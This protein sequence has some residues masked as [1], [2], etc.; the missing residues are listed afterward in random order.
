MSERKTLRWGFYAVLL[1]AGVLF[2]SAAFILHSETFRNYALGKIIQSAEQSTGTRIAVKNMTLTWYPLGVE[3]DDVTAQARDTAGKDPLLTAAHVT[4][5]LKLLPLLHR[6]VEVDKVSVDRPALHLRTESSGRTNLPASPKNQQQNS[7]LETQVALLIIRDGLIDYDDRRI[8]LSAELRGFRSQ[9]VFD[10]ATSSY[11]GQIAY[12]L[13]R[14][15]TTGIRTFDHKAEL[16]FVADATHC[17]VEHVDLSTLQSHLSMHGDLTSYT[18]PV[19][20]GDYT[21][22]ISGEDLR[23][24][25]NNASVPAGEVSLQGAVTYRS[26]QGQTVWDRT[27]LDG[28]LESG[29]LRLSENQSKIAV[30]AV[31]GAYRLEHGEL[32]LE[33]VRADA[34]GGHLTS[35]FDVIDLKASAGKIH[36]AIRGASVEQAGYETGASNQQTVHVAGMADLDIGASWKNNIHNVV[37]RA[38]VVIRSPAGLTPSRNAIP[39]EG[40]VDVDYDAARDRTSFGQSHLRTGNTQL[41]V[42][43]ILSHDS[44]LSVQLT[45]RDLQELTALVSTAMPSNG[46]ASV[47][48]YDLHGAAEFTGRLSGATKNPHIDGRISGAGIQ[49][50]GTKWR[51]LRAHV[52]LD[53]HA[54]NLDDGSLVGADKGRISFSGTAKLANW[55]LDPAAPVSLHTRIENVSAAD[56]QQVGK[57]SYPVQG[58]L[59]G[60]LFL[61]GSQRHP[62]GRGH[63]EL[64]QGVAW[65]EPLNAFG[66]DF[67]ADQQ[68]VH[69]TALARSLAGAVTARVTYD[70]ESRHYQAHANTQGLNLEQVHILQQAEGS[71]TGQMTAEVSGSGTLDDPQWT[72]RVQIPSLQVRGEDFKE[73]DA[74]VSV[75]HKHADLSFHSTVEQSSVQIKGTVELT[76]AYPAKVIL[77]TGEVPIGPL[78]DKFMHGRAQGATGQMEIHAT[79][80]G[81]L[82]EPARFEGHAEIPTLHL[83]AKSIELSNTHAVTLDYRA[84]VLQVANAELKGS[85]TDIR[86]NGSIPMQGSG[87]MNLTANGTLDLKALDAWANGGHSSGQ[88][89]LQLHA[90][91]NKTQ[92]TVEGNVRIVNAVYT[93]DALP[94]GIESLNGEISI[95][96]SRLQVSNLSATAGGGTL[97]VGGSATYGQN[98]SF[99][100]AL[101]AKSVRVRQ[102]GVRAV[103]D[104]NLA[105]VGS[106]DNSTLGGRVTIHKL[107]FNQAADLADIVGQFSNDST[108][109]E[110][111]SLARHLKLSVAVQ[112]ADDLNLS[113]SQLSVAGSA[114]LNAVGTLADPILL[115]RVALAS[116][117]VFFLGKRFEIQSGT[118]AFVNTVRTDPVVSLYVSTVVQQYNITVNLVGPLDRLK[119]TYTSDP[120]LPTAD[121]INLLAFGQTTADAASKAATPASVGAESAVANAV[122]GQVASQVQKLTGVSQLT[123]NPLAGS[124]QNPGSQ[125]A[126][127]QRVSGNILLTFST[128]I[129][130]AQNQSIQVQYQVKRNVTVSVLRDENGGYGIDVRYHKAF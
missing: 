98:S 115:G 80:N 83:Q 22:A 77:D 16:H 101:D 69:L 112:S 39:I 73:L 61:T 30:K 25:I 106:T 46:S 85:G 4:V 126:I 102:S 79:L 72:G 24:I 37:A 48:A 31:R 21:A 59:D 70:P 75:Q 110:S 78:L 19:F 56:L 27:Y 128:D 87:D 8:P 116:G 94:I 91:G 62:V 82:K 57:T 100:L 97:T 17:L 93:S 68:S 9:V 3:F 125:V 36:F 111:S 11:K 23:W 26:A 120:A 89:K 90:Q 96:G 109:S 64:V 66:L 107:S 113:S 114:N 52:G 42:N 50:E 20:T 15:E 12:D 32:H 29:V 130:S 76:A 13:G 99:N 124:N 108:V 38:H 5:S 28:H 67:D 119:T 55:S 49:I 14:I 88:V 45:T 6:R 40:A 7:S 84:G 47:A 18:T 81:P 104:A 51:T 118:I 129:T 123:L 65:N 105:M 60:E 44:F 63:V 34:F 95:A 122:G 1:T 86:I 33:R 74:Q 41:T 121:I 10:R 54:F 2:L 127:Q 92:P 43:G 103:V 58:V 117:E 53:S 35:D 71:V